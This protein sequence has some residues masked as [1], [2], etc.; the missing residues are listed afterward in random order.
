MVISME[1]K[2]WEARVAMKSKATSSRGQVKV[3][4][5][6]TTC[7]WPREVITYLDK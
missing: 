6:V 5:L 1:S 2:C 7:V 3:G 4:E